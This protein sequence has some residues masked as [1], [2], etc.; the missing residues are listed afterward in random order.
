METIE[1][2]NKI[3]QIR[4]LDLFN[5]IMTMRYN[6]ISELED[7]L[8]EFTQFEKY[9][10]MKITPGI[11]EITTELIFASWEKIIWS[12]RHDIHI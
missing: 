7:W 2:K 12:F 9:R 3:T 1:V 5:S 6:L 4:A 8:I 10:K 11:C